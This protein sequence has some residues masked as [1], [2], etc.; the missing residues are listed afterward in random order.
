M[1]LRKMLLI[2]LL[3]VISELCVSCS[4]ENE[5]A[6]IDSSIVENNVSNHYHQAMNKPIVSALE[7][8]LGKTSLTRAEDA[9]ITLTDEDAEYI[10]SLGIEE[11]SKLKSEIMKI[12]GLQSDDDIED[13]RDSVYLSI[14]DRIGDKEFCKFNDFV[15]S[16]LFLPPGET[17]LINYIGNDNDLD[18]PEIAQ[19]YAL[20]AVGIDKFGRV[21]YDSMESTRSIEDCKKAFA[22]RIAITSVSTMAGMILPGAGWVVAACAVCDAADA[23]AKYALCIKQQN[24]K[25]K[26]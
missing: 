13:L 15:N 16:Y 8:A 11:L 12:W 19:I 2:G 10:N 18:S 6:Q 24:S 7:V 1:K 22:V 20:A 4:E 3:S 23:A 26:K 21:I 14:C 5:S 17:S 9:V 25:Q